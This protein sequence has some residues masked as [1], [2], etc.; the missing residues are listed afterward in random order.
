[1]TAMSIHIIIDGYNLIR[2]S[3]ELSLLDQQDIQ[4]GR[5]ALIDMLA[6]YKKIKRH[7][8]TVVFDGAG[9]PRDSQRQDRKKGILIIF[10]RNNESAD[11]VIKNMARGEKEKALIVSSD[12]DIV[13]SAASFRSATISADDFEKKLLL[14]RHAHG[15][16]IGID[17]YEGW[18]PTTKKKGPSRRLSR[19]Q[20]RNRTK[21]RKL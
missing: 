5:E 16:E 3:H 10:S 13:R 4:L 14:A 2:Q 9:A 8:I 20:R 11:S 6:M 12:R 15:V 1:M 19:R 17:D 21:L 7:R 18:K